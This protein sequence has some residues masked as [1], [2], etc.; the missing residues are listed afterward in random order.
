MT[1]A[2]LLIGHLR[3]GDVVKRG[4]LPPRPGVNQILRVDGLSWGRV[5]G[6]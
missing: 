5:G 1:M 6:E 3:S 4:I 2:E